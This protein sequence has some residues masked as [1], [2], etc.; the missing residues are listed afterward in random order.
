MS[1]E[2]VHSEMNCSPRFQNVAYG[3]RDGESR[4]GC[5]VKTGIEGMSEMTMV[6]SVET[7]ALPH[8]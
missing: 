3:T 4:N 1:W 2:A 7:V 8:S 5:V 6:K